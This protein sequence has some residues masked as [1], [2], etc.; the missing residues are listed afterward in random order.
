MVDRCDQP[1]IYMPRLLIGLISVIICSVSRLTSYLFGIKSYIMFL[2][3]LRWAKNE[4]RR[5]KPLG[6]DELSEEVR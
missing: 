5:L 4:W 2:R 1:S 6:I 3:V